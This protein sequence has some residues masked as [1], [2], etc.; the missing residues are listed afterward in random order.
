MPV[1]WI[2]LQQQRLLITGQREI[3]L[4]CGLKLH[5]PAR[6]RA[7]AHQ[8]RRIAVVSEADRVPQFVGDHVARDI[9]HRVGADVPDSDQ[10]SPIRPVRRERDERPD[11]MLQP[12]AREAGFFGAQDGR[13]R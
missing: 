5:R 1:C 2:K 13:G 7:P 8:H 4:S 6:G 11:R 3:V 12:R 9:G 10:S